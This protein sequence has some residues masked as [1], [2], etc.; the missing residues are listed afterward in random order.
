MRDAGPQVRGG[1]FSILLELGRVA[2]FVA[3]IIGILLL[4]VSGRVRY[5]RLGTRKEWKDP[6]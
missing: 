4:I 1:G 5:H 2:S 6:E 3:S